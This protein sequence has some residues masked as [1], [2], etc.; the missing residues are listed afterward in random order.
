MTDFGSQK[1]YADARDEDVDPMVAE[2]IDLPIPDVEIPTVL[3]PTLDKIINGG[4]TAPGEDEDDWYAV[5]P[6]TE[7]EEREAAKTRRRAAKVAAK[8]AKKHP[9]Y[10]KIGSNLSEIAGMMAISAG[11]WLITPWCGLVVAGL[12]LILVGMAVSRDGDK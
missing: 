11:F 6:P 4:D 7:K 8:A 9:D 12:C 3:P 1:L 10:R 2:R 5:T